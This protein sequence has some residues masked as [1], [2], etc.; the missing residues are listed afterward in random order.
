GHRL[1]ELPD[2]GLIARQVGIELVRLRGHVDDQDDEGPDQDE[3][4]QQDRRNTGNARP[5]EQRDERPHRKRQKEREDHGQDEEPAVIEQRDRRGRGHD[6]DGTSRTVGRLWLG[7][8]RRGGEKSPLAGRGLA[9]VRVD[10][11]AHAADTRVTTMSARRFL[12]LP[13]AVALSYAGS[14]EPFADVVIRFG[15]MPWRVTRYSLAA[16]ARLAEIVMFASSL[17]ALSE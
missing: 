14:A 4:Q 10:G 5:L 7:R 13:S 11:L 12:A 3:Q 17:P 8:A 15:S 16:S 1:N 2:T 9:C 6:P